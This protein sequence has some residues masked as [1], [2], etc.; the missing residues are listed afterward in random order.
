MIRTDIFPLSQ[1]RRPAMKRYL[2]TLLGV[3]VVLALIGG[4]V[5][6]ALHEQAA[7]RNFHVVT[8]GVLYRSGQMS[9]PALKRIVHDYGIRTIVCLRDDNRAAAVEEERYCGK[10]ELNYLRIP[11][12]H[13]EAEDGRAPVE[14]G[15]RKFLETVRDPRKQPVLI[16][17]F[18]GIHRTGGYCAVYRMECEGWDNARAIAEMKAYGYYNLANEGDIL[19][20]LDRY[21]PGQ[22]SAPK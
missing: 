13:W 16:H 21:R 18:A 15:I 4:P 14:E 10:E 19:G 11:P 8:D 3:L 7:R 5:A 6:L 9:L 22:L 12:L 2:P 1:A 17:C 20:Y